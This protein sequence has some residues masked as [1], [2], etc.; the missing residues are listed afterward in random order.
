MNNGL[1]SPLVGFPNLAVEHKLRAGFHIPC[2]LLIQAGKE[3]ADR[4]P[5]D[6]LVSEGVLQ[7][8]LAHKIFVPAYFFTFVHPANSQ[9]KTDFLL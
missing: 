8:W 2:G 9:Q 1:L 4:S 7:G 5:M 3:F 6:H